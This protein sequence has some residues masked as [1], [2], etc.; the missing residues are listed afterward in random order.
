MADLYNWLSGE[1]TIEEKVST[2]TDEEREEPEK[3]FKN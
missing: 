2:F 1:Y 3:F